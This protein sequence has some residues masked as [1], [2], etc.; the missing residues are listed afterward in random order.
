M[1]ILNAFVTPDLALIG[2]DTDEMMPDGTIFQGCKLITLPQLGAVIGFRGIDLVMMAC[3]PFFVGFKGTF[4]AMVEAMP[5]LIEASIEYCRDHPNH[6]D[7]VPAADFV[8]VGYSESAERMIGHAFSRRPDSE[9]IQVTNDFPQFFAP[10]WTREDLPE[11]IRA[12]KPGMIAVAQSQCQL[13]RERG[14]DGFPA[15]GRYFIAEVRRH[16]ILIEQA[17]E[18][19]PR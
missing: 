8:L 4:D 18:F 6:P 1:T 14:P 10:L 9:E 11:G 5:Q 17:F 16:S 2:A 15:G 12:D 19:P 3:S 13:A 7:T